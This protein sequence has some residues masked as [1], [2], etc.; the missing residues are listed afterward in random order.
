MTANNYTE[1]PLASLRYTDMY[2]SPA[3]KTLDP[4]VRI[5]ILL[6]AERIKPVASFESDDEQLIPILQALALDFLHPNDFPNPFYHI[7]RA[8]VLG[9]YQKALS[10]INP[11]LSEQERYNFLHRV[12]GM[13]FGYPACCTERFLQRDELI[14]LGKEDAPEGYFSHFQYEVATE[15][16]KT[17]TYPD[18]WNYCLSGFIPCSIHCKEALHLLQSWKAVIDK[19]DP[20]A[21]GLLRLQNQQEYIKQK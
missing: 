5:C 13:F 4:M 14:R 9:E 15:W 18:A 6:T 8:S 19:A 7:G 11:E 12:D 3:W 1:E 21:A 17:E 2:M 16:K 20:E 10:Q